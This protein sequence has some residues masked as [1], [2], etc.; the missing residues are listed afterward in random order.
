MESLVEAATRA[1]KGLGGLMGVDMGV[2]VGRVAMARP[3]MEDSEDTTP[4]TRGTSLRCCPAM[5][6]MAA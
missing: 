5:T 3:A 4:L 6:P 2:R 1:R